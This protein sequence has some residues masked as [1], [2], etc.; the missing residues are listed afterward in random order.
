[1]VIFL[2]KIKWNKIFLIT[3]SKQCLE[4]CIKHISYVYGAITNRLWNLST[5][6][7]DVFCKQNIQGTI[8]Y[9]LAN[10]LL[11]L[12]KKPS[13]ISFFP[14][15]VKE[16]LYKLCSL[17]FVLQGHDSCYDPANICHQHRFP[18]SVCLISHAL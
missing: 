16:I 18:S 13:F 3:N 15:A 6:E 14:G 8:Y 17:N 1:M 4:S 10:I 2:F 7:T 12:W 11:S 5:N 9:P